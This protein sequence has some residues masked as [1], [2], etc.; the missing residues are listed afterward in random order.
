LR[1][2]NKRRHEEAFETTTDADDAAAVSTTSSSSSSRKAQ[3]VLTLEDA[4]EQPAVLAVLQALY[5][6]QPGSGLLSKL[7]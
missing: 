3:L 7:T 1:W 4:D 2:Q 6:N 5:C